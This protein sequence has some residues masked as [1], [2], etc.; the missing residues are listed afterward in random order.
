MQI[1]PMDQARQAGER[2]YHFHG[3]LRLRHN[4]KVSCEDPVEDAPLPP[5]LYVPLLQHSGREAEATVQP[6][7]HVLKGEQLGCFTHPTRGC[8]VPTRSRGV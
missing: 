8:S 6:G 1:S 2:L 5:R 7:Q 4:K 3:G